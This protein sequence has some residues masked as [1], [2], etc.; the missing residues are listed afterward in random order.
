MP[1]TV[2]DIDVGWCLV[3]VVENPKMQACEKDTVI[4]TEPK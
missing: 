4:F 2:I 1:S 3:K